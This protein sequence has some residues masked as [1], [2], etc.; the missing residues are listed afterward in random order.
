MRQIAFSCHQ[1][2]GDRRHFVSEEDVRVV[3]ERLPSWLSERL[4]AVHFDDRGRGRR[5]PGY[6]RQGRDE[7]ALC[8]L[9]PRVSLATFLRRSQ[10]PGQFGA[11]RG[12]QWPA[13]AVRRFMLYDV[14]LHELGHLQVIDR[15]ANSTRRRFAS[16]RR[17]QDFAEH[18]CRELWSQPCEHPDP[19]HGPPSPDELD[20]VLEGWMAANGDYKTA[21]LREQAESYD[22]AVQLLTRAVGRFPGHALALE[23]L[24]RLTYAG[25]GTAQS[26]V[27]AI[28]HLSR[29]V[30]LDPSLPNANLYLGLALA[31]ELRE[32]EARWSL[33]RAIA[34]DKYAP[35]ATAA[36]ADVLA[37]WGYF[38][39]AETLFKKAMKTDPKCVLAI[40]DYGRCLIRDANP[41]AEK[42]IGRAIELFERAVAVEPRDAESHYRLGDALVCIDGEEERAIQHLRRALRLRPHHAKAVARLAEMEAERR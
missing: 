14:F 8:A 23:L 10:S 20:A 36:Y 7:I 41:D 21:L 1:P 33:E 40:R 22:E 37:D 4:K 27:G 24:G 26:T 11:L 15:K 13:L 32:T 38:A 3:L 42:N 9:P 31:R 18:W 17:A 6:V 29:A 16:E 12:C 19:V 28:E 39:E 35:V 25:R 30:R 2:R 5:C 34:L